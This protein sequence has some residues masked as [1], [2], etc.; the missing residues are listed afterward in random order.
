VIARFNSIWRL[1]APGRWR[2]IFDNGSPP[3]AGPVAGPQAG[4]P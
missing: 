4:P 2:V 1:E 3:T